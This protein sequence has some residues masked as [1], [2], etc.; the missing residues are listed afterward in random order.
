MVHSSNQGDYVSTAMMAPSTLPIGGE[1]RMLRIVAHGAEGGIYQEFPSPSTKTVV[2][3]WVY[4]RRGHVVL[5]PNTDTAGPNSWNTKYNEWELLR[6]CIDGTPLTRVNI[7]NEDA[8][9]ADFDVDRVEIKAF[10]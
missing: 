9:G 2:S 3:V 7:Y 10:N 1:S 6:F 8:S 4:V 5:A